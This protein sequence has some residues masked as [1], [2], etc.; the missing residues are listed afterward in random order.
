MIDSEV[1]TKEGARRIKAFEWYEAPLPILK[2]VPLQRNHKVVFYSRTY[3]TLD[4]ET[5]NDGSQY[6]WIYQ[7]AMRLG[8]VYIYGRKPSELISLLIRIAER[9]KLK[10]D[11]R[12]IIYIHN[13]SY[14][15]QYLKHYLRQYDASIKFFAVNTH[16]I[17]ICDVLGFR[18]LCSYKLTN[19]SLDALSKNYSVMYVKDTGA[20]NYS[21]RRYQDTE[22]SADDWRYMFSDVAS[23]YDGVGAYI[24]ANGYDLAADAPITSTGFVRSD[25]RKASR[26]C[27]EWRGEFLKMQLSPEQYNLC[28]QAFMGGLTISSYKYSGQT[29][30]GKNIG[31]VDFTSSYPARQC[32]D[33]FPMGKPEDYGDI[34]DEEELEDLIQSKCCVFILYL[35]GAQIR[36]G[37][38]APYIP[39]SKLITSSGVVKV[40]GKVVYADELQIALTEIDYKIIRR[41]YTA[42]EKRV[43]NL[44]TF[45]RG[46]LP[47]WL[48]DKVMEYFTDKCTLKGVD[49]LLYMKQKNRLN[50]IFGMTATAITREVIETDDDLILKPYGHDIEGLEERRQALDDKAKEQIR[51][52]YNNY[53][54]FLPY[55]WALYTTAHAR[56]AL[57][58]LIETVGYEYFL[59]CDTDSEFFIVTDENKSRLEAYKKGLINRAQEAGRFV[60]N[61][62]LGAAEDEAPIRAFRALHAKCYAME[63]KTKTGKYELSVVIAGVPK[64]SIKW[65]DGKPVKRT[66]AEEL[67]HIDALKDGFTFTHCGGTRTIYN[68]QEPE[69]K[70][71][72]GHVTELASSAIICDIEKEISDTMYTIGADYTLLNIVQEE[73]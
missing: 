15:L 14:D 70:E 2:F 24:R 34:E 59:Y 62:F 69:I 58:E 3:A 49:D 55:Q 65:I 33:Y 54:S 26:A 13:A 47:T 44:I 4:T 57:V 10:D 42:E 9:Y 8:K 30:R 7:W 31:H 53:N 64:S 27:E 5:S 21:I 1:L 22:L 56:A 46:M 68:E 63:E 40:N 51:K 50:G 20:I 48:T 23:Q 28:R 37:V 66:N 6:G 39:Y 43:S 41:Q 71:I 29:I 12:I 38:T 32:L 35:K 36:Y 25:C 19:L 73:C 72:D 60:G 61:K 11:K 52:F 16:S 18:I 45:D 17:L 67:G